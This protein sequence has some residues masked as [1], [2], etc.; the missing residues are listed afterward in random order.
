MQYY[1]KYGSNAVMNMFYANLGS[2]NQSK[3]EDWI[4]NNYSG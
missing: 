3:L 2:G 1:D 4:I